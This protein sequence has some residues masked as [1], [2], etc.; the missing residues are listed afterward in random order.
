MKS[1]ILSER[2]I[3]RY[4]QQI[5]L[6][7]VGLKGQEEIKK[8]K[9]IVIGAGGKGTSVMQ[10]LT[11][12]GIGKLGITDN[13]QVEE[14]CLSRQRLY[15]NSDLGK[16]K[17]IVTKQKLMEINHY[18][19]FELHNVCLSESN[20]LNICGEYDIL[21]DATDNYP[22][23]YLINDTAIKLNKPFIFG[24][25]VN[26]EIRVSVFNYQNGPSLRCLYPKPPKENKDSASQDLLA[27]GILTGIAGA[28]MA[29]EVVKVILKL[30]TSL[31]GALYIFNM[32]DY[33][34]SLNPVKKQ[35][36]NFNMKSY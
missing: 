28:V 7:S 26:N 29:N 11:S 14:S 1:E 31:S 23:R 18:V 33:T 20:I 4:S 13:Y 30:P 27:P 8:A 12:L 25:V 15:G 34:T 17:A 5:E 22:S 6:H 2:E 24:A 9:V 21:L 10:H 19:D 32:N 36:S 3:R 16:Q 35:S